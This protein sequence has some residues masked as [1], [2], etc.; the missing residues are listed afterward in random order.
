L[1]KLCDADGLRDLEL[2]Q[3]NP[4][5]FLSWLQDFAPQMPLMLPDGEFVPRLPSLE[6]WLWDGEFCGHIQFR[7]EPGTPALPS[8]CLGD[9][10]YA[11]LPAKRRRGYATRALGLLLSSS[12]QGCRTW[13]SPRILTTRRRSG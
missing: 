6:R 5:E 9:I 10:G 12:R 11:V 8:Y 2:T 7:W 1:P 3:A 4:H 13:S